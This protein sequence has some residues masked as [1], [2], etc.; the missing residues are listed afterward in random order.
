MYKYSQFVE[1]YFFRL[2][3]LLYWGF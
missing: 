1:N 3:D 2:S